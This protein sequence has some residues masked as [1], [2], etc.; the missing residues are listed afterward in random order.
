MSED[1]K[2]NKQK[3]KNITFPKKKFLCAFKIKMFKKYTLIVQESVNSMQEYL[4]V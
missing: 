2:Q 1:R 3:M 4:Y